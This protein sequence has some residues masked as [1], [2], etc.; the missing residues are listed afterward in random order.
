MPAPVRGHKAERQHRPNGYTANQVA[1]CDSVPQSVF[2]N[3][4]LIPNRICDLTG[5][6]ATPSN[7]QISSAVDRSLSGLAGLSGRGG[8]V[9][10]LSVTAKAPPNGCR[11]DPGR[12]SEPRTGDFSDAT[13][14]SSRCSAKGEELKRLS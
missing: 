6:E 11:C 10:L 7:R 3:P 5:T 13:W 8:L 9:E 1:D 2:P 4:P 14:C 12:A